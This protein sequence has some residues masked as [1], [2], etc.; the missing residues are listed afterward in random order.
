[1]FLHSKAIIIKDALKIESIPVPGIGKKKKDMRGLLKSFYS[2]K[3]LPIN[4]F[5][6]L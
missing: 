6:F 5:K 4:K 2:T 1:M 3:D